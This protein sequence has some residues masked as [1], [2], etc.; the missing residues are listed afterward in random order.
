MAIMNN[1]ATRFK[2]LASGVLSLILTLG[3]ARFAYTPLLPIMQNETWLN[4]ASG[5]W[6]ASFNYMGYL[7]GALIA[8]LLSDLVLKDLLYRYGLILAVLSTIAMAFTDNFIV[9]SLL[10]FVAGLSS[11]AGLLIGSGLIL[12]W[13]MSHGHRNELGIHFSGLGLGIAFVSIFVLLLDPY[14]NWSE[15]WIVLAVIGLLLMIPAWTWLPRPKKQSSTVNSHL[16]KPPN[17]QFIFF[18]QIAYFCAGFGYAVTATFIVDIVEKQPL[19]QGLGEYVFLAIGLAAAPACIVWDFIARKTGVLK[20][21][22]I[23]YILQIVSSI[24]PAMSDDLGVLIFSALLFG[25]TFIGIVSLVLTM[26]GRFYPSK[27]AVL[28]GKLTLSYGVAQIIA[29][30]VSGQIAHI[31]GNYNAA[32]YCAA[33][34]VGLGTIIIAYLLKS[35]TK[36]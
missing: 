6:L 19:L 22:F 2:V 9:W 7:T 16:D 24:L 32:L 17:K 15:Q 13:L 33:F 20:A 30:A 11:A 27:P 28:M 3:I 18:M 4:A 23:A 29:P 35:Q 31:N 1:S 36:I 26:A 21:L 14:L 25:G 8:S 12:N 10:R 34:I 5:G